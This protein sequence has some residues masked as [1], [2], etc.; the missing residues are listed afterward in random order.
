MDHFDV[1]ICGGGLAGL[2]LGL[3]LRR[4]LPQ[5]SV[6]ILERTKRPLPAAAH[7]V[8]ES[9]VELGSMYF[10]DLG[11][12]TN[13][14]ERQLRKLGLRFFPG[15]GRLPLQQRAELGATEEPRVV[16]YQIDRGMFEQDLRGLV[17]ERGVTLVEGATVTDVSIGRAEAPHLVDYKL[18]D[19]RHSVSC[20]WLVDATGRAFLLKRKLKLARGSGHLAHS[21][22]FRMKGRIDITA[23]V[24]QS[25]RAWHDVPLAGE[26]WRSTNHLMGEGYWLW[27]IPLAGDVTSV[28][29]VVHGEVHSFDRVRTLEHLRAFIREVEPEVARHLE[30]ADVLDFLCLNGFSHGVSRSWS[31]E[32]WAI[33]GVAGAFLD[34][35]YSNGSDF[36]ALA[37]CHTVELIRSDWQ[38]DADFVARVGAL[39]LQYHA[40]VAGSTDIFRRAAPIYA[41]A[42]AMAAKIYWDNF[43][44]WSFPC[45]YYRQALYRLK[46][47]ALDAFSRP[48]SRF[49]ELSAYV[50]AL[51]S[52][53]S[54]MAPEAP[55]AGFVGMPK[56]PSLAVDAHLALQTKMSPEETLTYMEKRVAEG[57]EMVAELVLRVVRELGPARARQL[58]AA[59]DYASWRLPIE[60]S[61]LEAKPAEGAQRR[62]LRSPVSRDVERNLGRAPVHPEADE[63]AALLAALD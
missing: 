37:N 43:C 14:R 7:K 44:Y 1:V 21:G 48:G 51:L 62:H 5:L 11:L 33:V 3:Q 28:G 26:R 24:P 54:R 10:E 29:M 63:A 13:L 19:W 23:M 41:H 2:T 56:W 42:R 55:S 39:N 53:W 40:F 57:E 45:Q 22:W 58:L 30:H 52:T 8:G 27:L 38:R 12:E 61:R 20:R 60:R 35:L 59:V 18:G 50:Q 47:D 31:A 15:G 25:E 32:R 16:S 34:P 49:V 36:I 4:D 9:A 46:G 17:Q 6:L